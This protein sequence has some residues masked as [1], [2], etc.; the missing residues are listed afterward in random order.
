MEKARQVDENG[1]PLYALLFTDGFTEGK[2]IMICMQVD[3]IR[4]GLNAHGARFK[5]KKRSRVFAAMTPSICWKLSSHT[6]CCPTQYR[7]RSIGG[8]SL[9]GAAR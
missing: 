4:W 9:W 2:G 3:T 5:T 6:S 7:K 8:S 1:Q